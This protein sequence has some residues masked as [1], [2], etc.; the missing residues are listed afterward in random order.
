MK[1]FVQAYS[2]YLNIPYL[3]FVQFAGMLIANFLHLPLL[4]VA[5]NLE[6]CALQ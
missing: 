3:N 6:L 2:V 5:V 4:A 1:V